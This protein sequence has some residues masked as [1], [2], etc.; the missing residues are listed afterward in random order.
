[1]PKKN[2][3]KPLKRQRIGVVVSE[4]MDKTVV[5]ALSRSTMHPKYLKRYRITQRV[6]AHDLKNQYK[7]G[8]LVLIEECRPLSREKRWRVVK[9]IG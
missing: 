9:K 8:D 1:M 7:L 6:K 3:P 5:V 2:S 4:K